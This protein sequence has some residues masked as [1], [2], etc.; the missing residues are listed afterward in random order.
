[1]SDWV[2]DF[3][4]LE[5]IKELEKCLKALRQAVPNACEVDFINGVLVWTPAAAIG[6][7]VLK[8]P[9]ETQAEVDNRVFL[10]K[11]E[12]IKRQIERLG[13]PNEN[14]GETKDDNDGMGSLDGNGGPKK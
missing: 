6:Y 4:L 12:F 3:L 10:A 14:N 1:M 5:E 13:G 9:N 11:L 7:F 2:E 8:H